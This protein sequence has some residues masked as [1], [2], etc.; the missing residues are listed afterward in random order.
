[1]KANGKTQNFSKN[2]WLMGFLGFFGFEGFT[3]FKTGDLHYLFWFS[4]FSF[5]SYF[6]IAKISQEMKDERYFKNSEKAKL[7]IIP[8]PLFT[9]FIIGFFSGYTFITKEIIILISA[10]GWS[11]TL[12]F[13]AFLFWYY[14]K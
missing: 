8:I 13:Y 6:F 2:K 4:F 1:M 12:I 7:K 9:L 11:V 3:Y 14:D 5:F 10:L